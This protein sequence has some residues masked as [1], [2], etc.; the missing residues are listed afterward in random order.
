[1][2]WLEISIK[3]THDGVEDV[4]AVLIDN[5]ISGMIINDDYDLRMTLE[6]TAGTWDYA[7]EKLLNTEK[8]EAEIIFYL[9]PSDADVLRSVEQALKIFADTDKDMGLLNIDIKNVNDENWLD[10][11]KKF[12]K[13]FRIG[14]RIVVV[15]VWEN[16]NEL[17]LKH[18]DIIFR[19]DPGHVFGTGLH[20]STRMCLASLERRVAGGESVFDIGCGSGILSVSALL[21]GAGSAVACDIDSACAVNASGNAVLNNVSERFT[22]FTGNLI[23]DSVFEQKMKESAPFGI[24]CANIIA[25]IIID[26]APIVPQFLAE[27]G[28]FISSGIIR[29]RE[30]E[31]VRA[32]TENGFN[33]IETMRED[34]WV[35]ITAS[36]KNPN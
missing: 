16:T 3:T 11:W 9:Q 28:F 26:L 27:D 24:V 10:N 5:N 32:L 15:P 4:C 20:Q 23:N 2:E 13:P 1:M 22:A 8:G 18:D 29:S 7:D 35:C 14:E 17:D 33:I 30:D 12:Y 31:V 36:L 19:I 25:D 34:E 6:Q 21:L